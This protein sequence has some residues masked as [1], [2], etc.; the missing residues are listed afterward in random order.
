[1][2]DTP[3]WSVSA[4]RSRFRSTAFAALTRLG[5]VVRGVIYAIIGVLAVRIAMHSPSSPSNQRGA[6]ETI[7]KQPFGH[8]LVIAVA[9]G[10]GA[11]ALW[12]FVQA[13]FGFGPEGGGDPSRIGR[14]SAAA[15]GCAYAGL[16]ALAVAILLGASSQSSS[17]PQK[18]AAGVL[19]W[20]GGQWLVG[21]AGAVL[22]GVALFQGYR[23]VSKKF[24]D[25]DKTE[26]MG[27]AVRRWFTRLGVFG[28]VARM[29]A[30][31]LIGI[32]VLKAAIDYAPSDAVG[33]DGA[34]SKLAHQPYGPFLLVVVAA[35]L[36]AFGV[37][38]IAESRYRRI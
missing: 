4:G 16:C 36:V 2:N 31:G 15:S 35:G 25:Q 7:Q 1:M 8:W 14:I 29:I 17:N 18:S 26:E 33:L 32:F 37:Y 11:Y 19:G 5:F 9:I 22:I 6:L 3:A 20:P 12:R 27:P 21:T 13:A 24:L 28:H 10:L 23:G 34:L 38:S 30:F